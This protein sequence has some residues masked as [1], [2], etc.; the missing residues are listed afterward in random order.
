MNREN[1]YCVII[2][3]GVGSRIWPMSRK[4]L[5]KQ[6]LDVLGCGSSMLRETF[7]RYSS[8]VNQENIIVVTNYRYR[9][10]VLEQLPELKGEQVLCEPIGR[11][12]APAIAY[13]VYRL[14]KINENA[15]IIVTP[16]DHYVGDERSLR[17]A[18]E[19]SLIFAE[20]R[21]ALV[22][23]GVRP[24]HPETAYGYIQK[25]NEER[26]SPVKCFS[27]KPD[28]DLA[29]TLMQCG[30]FLWNT[31]IFIASVKH[32]KASFGRHLPELDALFSSI[33]G[34]LATPFEEEAIEAIYSESQAIS[35]ENGLIERDED[36][37]V[38]AGEFAWSDVG[39]WES[40]HLHSN[41]DESNNTAPQNTLLHN[42]D[43]SIISIPKGK[44]A[45][46]RGLSNYIVVDSDNILLICPRSE[47][48][49]IKSFADEVRF[50]RDS[51]K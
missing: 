23:M 27:E 14:A 5:P 33:N 37:Y 15:Q 41:R 24:T 11:N 8:M 38:Y 2:A 48:A 30:E 44:I 29:R 51:N 49:S 10:L 12:T 3:G 13:A 21:N 43:N 42:T 40:V 28:I 34:S 26:I 25:S 36:I 7:N 17:S 31:G 9:D 47:E 46:I 16:A 32:F 1:R 39:T 50:I 6:F 18:V 4:R 20:Q 35:I 19:E 22:T 45:V